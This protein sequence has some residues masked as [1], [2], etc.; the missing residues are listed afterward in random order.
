MLQCLQQQAPE[1]VPNREKQ[2]D[3]DRDHNRNDAQHTEVIGHREEAD[4]R[5]APAETS[6]ASR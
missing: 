1:A 4:S 6:A 3:H 5:M 2:Q